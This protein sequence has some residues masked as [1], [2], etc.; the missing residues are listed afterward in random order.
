MRV[1][2]ILL[3]LCL[4]SNVVNAAVEDDFSSICTYQSAVSAYIT[5]ELLRGT[6][7]QQAVRNSFALFEMAMTKE[8]FDGLELALAT[9]FN[10]EQRNAFGSTI[11]LAGIVWA[12]GFRQ[13][14]VLGTNQQLYDRAYLTCMEGVTHTGVATYFDAYYMSLMLQ[15]EDKDKPKHNS[16]SH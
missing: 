5:H 10:E 11:G 9:H 13:G 12:I 3:L 4:G 14:W 2:S 1:L 16:T 7:Y 15:L 6:E 8:Y